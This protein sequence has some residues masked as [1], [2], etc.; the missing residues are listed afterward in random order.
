MS[1]FAGDRK[2]TNPV[3]GFSTSFPDLEET[4]GRKLEYIVATLEPIAP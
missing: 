2:K 4:L 1:V 3:K